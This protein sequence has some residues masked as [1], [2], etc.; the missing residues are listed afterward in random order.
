[1]SVVVSELVKR[2]PFQGAEDPALP[3]G[4]WGFSLQATGD[5]S[6]NVLATTAILASASQAKSGSMFSLEHFNMQTNTIGS[7][8][9]R[10]EIIGAAFPWDIT[11]DYL[12]DISGTFS[13]GAFNV[14]S[15]AALPLF[16]GWQD[17]AATALSIGFTMENID[18]TILTTMAVGYIWSPRSRSVPGGPRRPEGALY[19]N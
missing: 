6:G 9:A 16:L 4:M 8:Q 13:Q 15:L 10:M 2:I 19:G 12:V 1:M 5:V 18:S 14:R 7:E 17:R 3:I 11:P